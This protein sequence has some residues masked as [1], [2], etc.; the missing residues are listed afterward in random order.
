MSEYD[1]KKDWEE[2]YSEAY[3]GWQGYL[4]EAE[5]DYNFYLGLQWSSQ[6]EAYLKNLGR[7]AFVLN[8]IRRVVKLVSGYERKNRLSLKVDPIEGADEKAASQY[9]GLMLWQMQY[10]DAYRTLSNAFEKGP[11]ITGLNF[12]DLYVDRDGDIQMR[13][14]PYNKILTDPLFTQL[15]LKDCGYYLRRDHFTKEVIQFLMPAV[16]DNDLKS[17]AANQSDGKFPMMGPKKMQGRDI[18]TYDEFW[19]RTTKKVKMLIDP[20]TGDEAQ[21]KGDNE[22]LKMVLEA[23]PHLEVYTDSVPTVEL[24][25]FIEGRKVE[26]LKNPT[27]LDD[28]N[29]TPLMG[30][31]EPEV[32]SDK[33]KIS[34]IVRALRDPQEEY[35]KRCS[36]E[37]DIIESRIN[38]GWLAKVG[39]LVNEDFLYRG[40]Q[41][42]VG[43]VNKAFGPNEDFRELHGGDIP[44]GY[45]QA[46]E[47]FDKNITQIS[48]A[49][50]EIFGTEEK[51]I[52]GILSRYRQGA[53]L[54]L[55]QD[56][57]DNNRASKRI[58]GRKLIKLTQLHYG[59]KKIQRIINEQPVREFYSKDFGKYD[60][61]PQEGILTDS[62]RQMYY[63]E[64]KQLKADGAPIPWA[65]LFDAMPM[66]MKDRLRD[67]VAQQ[68]KGQSE[69]AQLEQQDKHSLIELQKSMAVENIAQAQERRSKSALDTIKTAAEVRKMD[70][71]SLISLVGFARQMQQPQAPAKKK[72][73]EKE[74]ITKR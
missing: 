48:G 30:Y 47:N 52:P 55:F 29:I 37:V 71:D 34:G 23:A 33:S 74:G 4:R 24:G 8:K 21:W 54:T 73:P 1:L 26:N 20:N 45:F 18:Y 14:I 17:M 12:V 7:A 10:M 22:S 44:P 42:G 43:W 62:Q 27:G 38:T 5:L 56:L 2:A 39:S 65:A 68:E 16:S 46:R 50:D 11:A 64:L 63:A 69:A 35:N 6:Q 60:C 28:F 40:G 70:D 58:V 51:D 25:V 13:R 53:A 36:Q 41:G 67:I 59:P 66:Q 61:T 32:S 72:Q 49:N 9:T 15:D 3:Y 19:R 31:F 57:F